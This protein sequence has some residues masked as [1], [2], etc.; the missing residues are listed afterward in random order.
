MD[1]SQIQDIRIFIS[2]SSAD[3]AFGARLAE[4]LRRILGDPTAVW[5]DSVGGLR[6][7]DSWWNAIMT[8]VAQRPIFLVIWSP[9]AQQSRWVNDEISLAWQERNSSGGKLI[10]PLMYRA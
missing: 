6:P 7:G 8:E 4:D 1:V 10:I 3:N 9:D 2:H 5:Y